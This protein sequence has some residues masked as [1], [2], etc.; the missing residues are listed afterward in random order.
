M[1]VL[2]YQHWQTRDGD[3]LRAGGSTLTLRRK[4]AMAQQE[5]GGGTTRAREDA[6]KCNN[7]IANAA[8]SR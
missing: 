8:A 3:R 6:N 1:R 2:G 7:Q 5:V 4:E